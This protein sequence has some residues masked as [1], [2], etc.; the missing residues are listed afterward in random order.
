MCN[1]SQGRKEQE[2]DYGIRHPAGWLIRNTSVT[3]FMISLFSL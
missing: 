1:L 3:I 2:G